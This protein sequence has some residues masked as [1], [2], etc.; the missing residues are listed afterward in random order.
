MHD[1]RNATE[2]VLNDEERAETRRRRL[3]W[4]RRLKI[5]NRQQ[6]LA[7]ASQ[8]MQLSHAFEGNLY[9]TGIVDEREIGAYLWLG[10]VLLTAAVVL[11]FFPRLL[12]LPLVLLAAAGGLSTL[13]YA[14]KT[15]RRFLRSKRQKTQDGGKK[16]A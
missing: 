3:Q 7:A 1:L 6:A 2:I 11:W 13:V 14:L 4:L 15:R 16:A 12:V 5:A 10:F 9:G 8:F